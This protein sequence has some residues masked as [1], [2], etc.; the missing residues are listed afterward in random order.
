MS[1]QLRPNLKAV[2][3]E[4]HNSNDVLLPKKRSKGPERGAEQSSITRPNG[5]KGRANKYKVV[6]ITYSPCRAHVTPALRPGYTPVAT[7]V[8][9]ETM[10]THT[11]P[12]ENTNLFPV[13][14]LGV[15]QT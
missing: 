9:R 3:D 10:N 2:I 1:L 5:S 15:Y 12:K 8:N 14:R 6:L 4:A 13:R 11:K 7:R